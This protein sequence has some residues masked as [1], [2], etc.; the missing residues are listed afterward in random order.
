GSMS[1]SPERDSATYGYATR[2]AWENPTAAIEWANTI[3]NEGTRADA[4]MET[5]RAYF[6]KDPEGA[7]QWLSKSGL[8][9]EQ[10]KR[11]TSS[12]RR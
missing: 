11:V 3:S 12:R 5:G 2:V 6:R 8:N 1:I 7:K 9:E 10:Q 4:L